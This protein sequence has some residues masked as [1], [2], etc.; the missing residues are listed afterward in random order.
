MPFVK[1]GPPGNPGG[2]Q[3]DKPFR[4][5]LSI[6]LADEVII[7]AKKIRKL[8]VV[9]RK[10]IDKAI[11]GDIQAINSLMDRIDGKAPQAITGADGKSSL[12]IEIVY[13]RT[14]DAP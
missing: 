5:A 9:A 13:P 14:D 12:I 2:Q 3:A 11:A 8:R 6:E 1:G 4:D 7:R 10:L